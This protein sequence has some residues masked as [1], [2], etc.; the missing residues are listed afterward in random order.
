MGLI[1][2]FVVR[3]HLTSAVDKELLNK[4]AFAHR[5]NGPVVRTS[6]GCRCFSAAL[7]L[8]SQS[9]SHIKLVCQKTR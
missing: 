4:V 8:N 6:R 1:V 5:R 9:E 2:V 7:V 3:L